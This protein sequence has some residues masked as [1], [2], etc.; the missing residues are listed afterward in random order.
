MIIDAIATAGA[1]HRKIEFNSGS[2]GSGSGSYHAGSNGLRKFPTWNTG[3]TSASTNARH[4]SSNDGSDSATPSTGAGA[5]IASFTPASPSRR[6][7]SS[8]HARSSNDR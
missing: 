7:S 8:A 6:I 3:A 1:A 2:P 5:V 4:T